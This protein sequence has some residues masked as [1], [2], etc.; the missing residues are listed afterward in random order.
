MFSDI[1]EESNVLRHWWRVQCSQTLMESAMVSSVGTIGTLCFVGAVV[2]GVMWMFV[3]NVNKIKRRTKAEKLGFKGKSRGEQNK[4]SFFCSTN[5]REKTFW[6]NEMVGVENKENVSAISL[7]ILPMWSSPKLLGCPSPFVFFIFW[8]RH[9]EK[10]KI[11]KQKEKKK[12]K[13]KKRKREKQRKREKLRIMY[14]ISKLK[15]IQYI[16]I[17]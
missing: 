16:K 3:G 11:F 15:W 13:R 12:K 6:F 9:W 14:L 5:K 2:C 10:Y 17:K 4:F 1:D 7:W 8:W